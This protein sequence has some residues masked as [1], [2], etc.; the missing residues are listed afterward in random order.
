METVDI[1]QIEIEGKISA[2]LLE[3]HAGNAEKK[4]VLTRAQADRLYSELASLTWDDPSVIP[5]G[6]IT[7]FG[8]F[9]MEIVT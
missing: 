9:Q 2:Y 8:E 1:T 7:K 6:T 5:K 3:N 4:L